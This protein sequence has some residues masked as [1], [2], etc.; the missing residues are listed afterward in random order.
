MKVTARANGDVVLEWPEGLV[1]T[2]EEECRVTL[3]ADG[4]VATVTLRLGALNAVLECIGKATVPLELHERR[5]H[6]ANVMMDVGLKMGIAVD[7]WRP[8]VAEHVLGIKL[9]AFEEKP[10]A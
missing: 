8:Y 6:V 4:R 10:K 1:G 9:G 7:K 5:A 3:D 2:P